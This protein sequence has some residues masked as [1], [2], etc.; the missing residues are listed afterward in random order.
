MCKKCEFLVEKVVIDHPQNPHNKTVFVKQKA[1]CAE[2]S[3]LFRNEYSSFFTYL[4]TQQKTLFYLL[5]HYFYPLSTTPTV[6]ITNL[7]K[8]L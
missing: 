7:N 6:T 8:G 5:K 1:V 2:K 4:S 3:Q